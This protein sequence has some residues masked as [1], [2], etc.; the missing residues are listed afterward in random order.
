MEIQILLYV[1]LFILRL[2]FPRN[3]PISTILRQRYQPV[4]LQLF[5]KLE[6]TYL[7]KEKCNSHI[8]FLNKCL[9]YDVMPKFLYFKLYNRNLHSSAIYK[10]MQ[11]K[12]LYNEIKIK[13]RSLN[14]FIREVNTILVDLKSGTSFLDFYFLKFFIITN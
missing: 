2:R 8:V 4:V 10:T 1:Y 3:K 14:Q 5:R 13:K 9:V 11:R 7:K 6:K 12:L